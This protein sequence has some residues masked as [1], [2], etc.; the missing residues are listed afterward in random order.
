MIP[1]EKVI[2]RMKIIMKLGTA[3]EDSFALTLIMSFDVHFLTLLFSSL[4]SAIFFFSFLPS[5]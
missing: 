1:G 4:L 5:N 3:D 2:E